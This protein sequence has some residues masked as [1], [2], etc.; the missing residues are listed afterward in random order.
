M[1]GSKRKINF[2]PLRPSR[3]HKVFHYFILHCYI[4]E[5]VNLFLISSTAC[6]QKINA[7]LFFFIILILCFMK[8]TVNTEQSMQLSYRNF[9]FFS[10]T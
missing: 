7:I 8:Y 10:Y 6:I 2:F 4:Y 9:C 1:T 5:L 3:L